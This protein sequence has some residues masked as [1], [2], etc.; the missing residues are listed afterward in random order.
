MN[1]YDL[2]LKNLF[3]FNQ[4]LFFLRQNPIFFQ[5]FI[6]IHSSYHVGIFIPMK[7]N[8]KIISMIRV[9]IFEKCLFE[10]IKINIVFQS[11]TA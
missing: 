8:R 5:N 4:F 3:L 9:F 10:R 1:I 6:D 2:S 7:I 11:K